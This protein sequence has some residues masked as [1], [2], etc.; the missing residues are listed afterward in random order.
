MAE[1]GGGV[2]GANI[3]VE[4]LNPKACKPIKASNVVRGTTKWG[5]GRAKV[6]SK[7]A[8]TND[9]PEWS[10]VRCRRTCEAAENRQ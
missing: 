9:A 1:G 5:T 6:E 10:T 3:A 8:G 7:R 2:S 4:P